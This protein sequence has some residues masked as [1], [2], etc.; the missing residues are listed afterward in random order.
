[1]PHQELIS[2]AVRFHPWDAMAPAALEALANRGPFECSAETG[3]GGS[4]IVLSHLSK[5][6]TAF[7]IEGPDQTITG[8]RQNS[9]FHLDTVF[10]S[11][12]K[13]SARFRSIPLRAHWIWRCSMDRM[14]IRFPNWNLLTYS[15]KSSKA[16]GW[17]WTTCRSLRSTNWFDTCAWNPPSCWKKWPFER[18]SSARYGSKTSA[19]MA[20]NIKV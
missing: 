16:A 15:R 2:R 4:T 20:G 18:H 17:C 3:C 8:L 9:D 7:A 11:K 14:P 13:P 12:V 1:M 6:H 5:H 19:R 10:S